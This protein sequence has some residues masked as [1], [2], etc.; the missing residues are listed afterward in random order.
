M[1]FV[2]RLVD[3]LDALLSYGHA[4]IWRTNP[5]EFFDVATT[6][7]DYTFVLRDGT[8]MTVMKLKGLTSTM[9]D[10]EMVAVIEEIA[11]ITGR[12]L[13]RSQGHHFSISYEFDPDSAQ[14]YAANA[15]RGTQKTAQ[16]LGMGPFID[17]I[18]E[19]KAAKMA[20]FCQVEN[21]FIA[22]YTTPAAIHKAEMK[23][24]IQERTEA[25]CTWP[26]TAEAL[27]NDFAFPQLRVRHK[28]MVKSFMGNLAHLNSLKDVSL[29]TERVSVRAY[30]QEAK[31]ISEP[32]SSPKWQ[33]RIASDFLKDIRV[34]TNPKRRDF[35]NAD[36]MMPPSFGEQLFGSTPIS[37]GIKYAVMGNRIHYPLAVSMGP[38]EPETFDRLIQQA[39]SMRLP[40]RICFSFKGSGT[41]VDYMNTLLAKTFPWASSANN[42]IKQ[43]YDD[44]QNYETKQNGVVPAMYITACTWADAKPSHSAKNG[45][46]YDLT[47][48]TDRATKLNR[49]LQSWGGCQTTDAFAAPIEGVLGS[50]AGLY[51]HPLGTIMAPPMPDAI[52]LSPMFRPTTSWTQADGNVLLRTKDGRFLHYQ[53]TSPRQNA[54]VT[55]LVGP[56]GYGKSTML[57]TL[58][59]YYLLTPSTE[60]E[61]PFLRCLD[62]GP[63]SRSIVDLVKASVGVNNPNIAQY[64]RIQNTDEYQFNPFDTPLGMEK[65]LP[66][67]IDFLGNLIGTICYSMQGNPALEKQLPGMI[68]T[69]ISLLYDRYAAPANGGDR[70]RTYS[71]LS[72]AFIT[73]KVEIHGIETDDRTTWHEVR[74]ALFEA[75]EVRA[76]LLA[77]RKAMPQLSDLISVVSSESMRSEYP[78][79][80]G[81]V[82]VLSLFG[83]AIREAVELFPMLNGETKFELGEA[84]VISLDMEELVPREQTERARWK[85]SIAFFIGYD[86]LTRDFFMHE[87]YLPQIPPR[88]QRYHGRRIK[89]LKTAR[90]RFSMDERQRF[91]KIPTAQSQV[92]GLIAEGRKNL[93]DIQVASQLFEHH[94]DASITLSSTVII[95]GAGN[96]STDEANNVKT[97]FDLSDAQ[98][99]AIRRMRPPTPA[100]AEAFIIF[101]TRDGNQTHHVMLS[102]GSMYLWLIATEAVDRTMRSLAYAKYPP[103]EALKRLAAKYPGGSVKKA[104]ENALAELND[105]ESGEAQSAD[106]LQTMVDEL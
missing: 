7:D 63:S 106:L 4:A 52:G 95:L 26:E 48:I 50:Q 16:R 49:A 59:L 43:S 45:V 27:L 86:I 17:A 80:I 89:A 22:L 14:S 36:H 56:M 87:D 21:T 61:L 6:D 40:F 18:V 85:A 5:R 37:V 93:V 104:I 28:T 57:N 42:Q 79:S 55:L 25:M 82:E 68:A 9:F 54:W 75:G 24:Q 38:S 41:G 102:D 71:A 33:P 29:M 101:R 70:A 3:N 83:R 35:N 74:D 98:M 53:Q 47:E 15:L 64:I 20:E 34:P 65:P 94:T 88:Y 32:G 44:L 77:H 12:D 81:G 78:D 2:D 66:N 76:A 103:Q 91:A 46:T 99:T 72:N 23:G 58:N 31:R 1:R 51:D 73:E 10:R 84:R 13:I 60:E 30:L 69:A 62:I 11:T 8:L 67:H 100:G 105:S 19:E 92:D 39:S 96:M 97:R 90:K